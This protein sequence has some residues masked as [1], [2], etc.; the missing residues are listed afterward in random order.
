MKVEPG[1][2]VGRWLVLREVSRGGKRYCE[3]QCECGTVREVYYRSLE[4]GTS[5][6][7]GCLRRELGKGRAADLTG[8]R[9]GRLEVLYR[10]PGKAE[11]YWVCR[12]DCGN[13]TSVRSTSL[14]KGTRSCGCIQREVAAVRGGSTI[15]ENSRDQVELN[16]A[17][18]TNIQ[19]IKTKTPPKNNKSGVKGVSWC[20]ERG[21]WEAYIQI[22]GKRKYLG[23]YGKFDEAVKAR[24]AAEELY[25]EPLLEEFGYE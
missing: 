20:A 17:L 16:R 4:N 13:I 15:S 5:Q 11:V 22:H 2:K 19:V 23:R 25:F 9:Y 8:K 7:C 24:K 10:D 3:C 21:L 14:T 1:V 6:S 12:C 18:N